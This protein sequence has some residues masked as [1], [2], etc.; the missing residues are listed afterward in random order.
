M[1]TVSNTSTADASKEHFD[2]KTQGIGYISRIR[3]VP[4]KRKNANDMLCCAINAIHGSKD[5]PQYTYF[6]VHVVG[7][8]AKELVLRCQPHVEQNRKVL[9]AFTIGDTYIHSY[10][11]KL[12]DNVVEKRSLLKGRLLRITHVSVDGQTVYSHADESSVG[13]ADQGNGTEG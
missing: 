7:E 2:L 6:D 4:G 1:T 11:K 9:V 3:T 12:P 13:N 8:K 10:D 5:D